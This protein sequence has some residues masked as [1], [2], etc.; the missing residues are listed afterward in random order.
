MI[1]FLSSDNTLKAVRKLVAS[2]DDV[3]VAVAFW[4]RDSA[5]ESGLLGKRKGNIF[6]LCDLLSGFCNADELERL[7]KEC[8]AEI[9]YREGLHSKVWMNGN[10][11]IVGS[12]NISISGLGFDKGESNRRNIEA[13]LQNKNSDA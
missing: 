1:Q 7:S 3:F 2:N 9:R 6:V 4:G 11:I 12:S 8:G 13:N 5:K 10:S